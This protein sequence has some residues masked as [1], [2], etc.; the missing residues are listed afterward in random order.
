M[1]HPERR[2]ECPES[3][4]AV[5]PLASSEPESSEAGPYALDP[6]VGED[7]T[8]WRT[9]PG[10]MTAPVRLPSRE[11]MTVELRP[12]NLIERLDEYQSDENLAYGALG[13][14]LGAILGIIGDWAVASYPEFE[15]SPL[16]IALVVILAVMTLAVA[17]W[18]YRIRR[19]RNRI[20]DRMRNT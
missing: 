20:E 15:V 1:A 12:M 17:L 10:E 4:Q 2:T 19:R 8:T 14:F 16:S 7:A 13:L 5:L 9:S 6:L 18:L 3:S 11:A